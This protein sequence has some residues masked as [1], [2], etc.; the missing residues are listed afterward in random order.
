MVRKLGCERRGAVVHLRRNEVNPLVKKVIVS[1][2][3]G[4]GALGAVVTVALQDG[5]ISGNEWGLIG[6]AFI[7][8]AWG[9]FS[10]NTTILAPSRAGETIAGPPKK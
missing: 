8:A 6:S 3:Y 4:L 5:V 1:L 10:S 7:A 9:K 2:V